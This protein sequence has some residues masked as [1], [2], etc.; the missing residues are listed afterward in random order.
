MT[1][2]CRRHR[3]RHPWS[4]NRRQLRHHL[5]WLH[6]W[7][8]C[9]V[10]SCDRGEG[11]RQTIVAPPPRRAFHRQRCG[12]AR[13][14]I[15]PE[16]RICGTMASSSVHSV[17]TPTPGYPHWNGTW[18][19]SAVCWRTSG[20]RFAMLDL[21]ARTRLIGIARSR[22]TIPNICF[23][24]IKKAIKNVKITMPIYELPWELFSSI[25]TRLL[26]R[27]SHNQPPYKAIWYLYMLYI[28]A[29]SKTDPHTYIF[30]PY[31]LPF[32]INHTPK[33]TTHQQRGNPFSRDEV[34][35]FSLNPNPPFNVLRHL[36]LI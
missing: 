17:R 32:F 36:R 27:V 16:T 18:S 11:R 15:W 9:D 30:S 1:A 31:K 2:K 19:S 22:S 13:R 7:C 29:C 14:R 21:S 26:S 33:Q 10:E 25:L 20:V 28:F 8:N 3:Y 5:Q 12:A 4:L 35:V 23:R 6:L 34:S 24:L